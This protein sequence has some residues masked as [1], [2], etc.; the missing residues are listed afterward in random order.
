MQNSYN[1]L[2]IFETLNPQIFCL[3]FLHI[4]VPVEIQQIEKIINPHS[5]KSNIEK[6]IYWLHVYI[7]VS[8]WFHKN[9]NSKYLSI[10]IVQNEI[11]WYRYTSIGDTD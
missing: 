11:T 5:P 1:C 7:C 6:H 4:H 10:Y 9:K 3:N 8:Y 2:Q